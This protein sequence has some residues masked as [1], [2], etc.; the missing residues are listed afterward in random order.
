MPLKRVLVLALLLI[1]LVGCGNRISIPEG[2]L[3]IYENYAR[4]RQMKVD[5]DF[6]AEICKTLREPPDSAEKN[7]ALGLDTRK[8]LRVG[9]QSFQVLPNSVILMDLWGVRTWHFKDIEARLDSVF[10]DHNT[11][12]ETISP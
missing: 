9:G 7:M 8:S 5:S 2:A 1:A 10:G 6:A 4:E 12:D 3:V 11:Q